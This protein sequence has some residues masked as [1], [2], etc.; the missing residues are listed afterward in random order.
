MKCFVN[1][2]EHA[3]MS[4]KAKY[5]DAQKM[6]PVKFYEKSWNCVPPNVLK[7]IVSNFSQFFFIFFFLCS[8]D[9][10]VGC[11]VAWAQLWMWIY[12]SPLFMMWWRGAKIIQRTQTHTSTETQTPK[13]EII[14]TKVKWKCYKKQQCFVKFFSLKLM[15]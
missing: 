9:S 2:V 15:T 12:H 5:V 14:T 6:M 13:S 4:I 1:K 8:L 10:V 11:R 3:I 7:F